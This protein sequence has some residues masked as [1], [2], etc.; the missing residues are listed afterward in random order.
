MLFA[1]SVAH[2]KPSRPEAALSYLLVFHAEASAS[3]R[4]LAFEEALAQ[5]ARWPREA[6]APV[7]LHAFLGEESRDGIRRLI[8]DIPLKMQLWMRERD[9]RHAPIIAPLAR[10]SVRVV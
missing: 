5:A 4:P 6:H 9:R 1:V 2:K 3:S 8:D 7:G 10:R